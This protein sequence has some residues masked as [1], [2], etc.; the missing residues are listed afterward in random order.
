MK[1]KIIII[2]SSKIIINK[3]IEKMIKILKEKNIKNK[4]I[5]LPIKKKVFDILRSPHIDK[6]SRDQFEIR[7]YK[8]IINIE[9]INKKEIKIIMKINVP[10]IINFYMK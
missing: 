5:N 8:K 2:S 4:I 1:I 10:A 7:K 9:K 3:F 6:D